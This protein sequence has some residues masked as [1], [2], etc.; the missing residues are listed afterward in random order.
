MSNL[1]HAGPRQI[2]PFEVGPLAFGCWR[3]TEH[4]VADGRALIESA[5]ELGM[6]L[7][8]NADVYGLDWGGDGFGACEELLGAVL[9][10]AP[11]LRDR[12]VLATKGGIVPP[13]PYDQSPQALREA[14]E[15]SLRRLGV[16]VID[17]YQIHRPDLFVH[18][19]D[20]AATLTALRDEGKIREVGVSNFTVA[21]YDALA[22]A[23]DFPMA[24]TQP[25]YSAVRLDPLRDGTFDRAMRDG[26]VPLA[27]SPLA[28]G[29]LATG[30]DVAPALVDVLDRIAHRQ[31]VDRASVA[32]AFVLA[33]PAAPVAIV[34]SQHPDRLRAAHGALE[35][36]L[37]RNDAY[38]IVE[39]S[40]GV[41][42]P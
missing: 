7:I 36:H 10:D 23:L 25:E 24:T 5:L 29:R 27:W 41:P 39:A 8:D 38:D 30:D 34:G 21:Q 22:A 20:V 31:G 9:A 16:E 42:L 32:L 33:H 15:A 11:G 1:V 12:L 19:H 13:I 18:P 14:C 35:V 40:E 28:G 4:T 3:F 17:L 26:V 6:N 2:G 37:D